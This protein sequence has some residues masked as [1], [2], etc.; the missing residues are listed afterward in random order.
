MVRSPELCNFL[1]YL[2]L[3]TALSEFMPAI[4]KE[5]GRLSG[6]VA[7]LATVAAHASSHHLL[8]DGTWPPLDASTPRL[9]HPDTAHTSVA[10]AL[11]WIWDTADT[12]STST[13]FSHTARV[14]TVSP[15]LTI[16]EPHFSSPGT[17]TTQTDTMLE[18]STMDF[19]FS[20]SASVSLT[21]ESNAYA[22]IAPAEGAT[23]EEAI[24]SEPDQAI[25]AEFISYQPMI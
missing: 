25:F 12:S 7:A 3:S 23:N 13:T 11:S 2:A 20:D 9:T 22:F 18:K 24:R 21:D 10:P 6:Q 5:L 19:L 17:V 14:E 1:G 15:L 16:Y 4:R 8:P